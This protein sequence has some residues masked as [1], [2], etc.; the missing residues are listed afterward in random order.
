[1]EAHWRGELVVRTSEV[2]LVSLDVE[3]AHNIG[4]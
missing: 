3:G 1:M 4:P 2:L